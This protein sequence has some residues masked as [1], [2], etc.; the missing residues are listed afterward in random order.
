MINLVAKK[1]GM[2]HLY[3][4]DGLLVPLTLIAFYDNCIVDVVINDNKDFDN[5]LI[6]SN[7][8]KNVRKVKKSVAGVFVKKNLPIHKKIYGSKIQKESTYKIG[9]LIEIDSVLKEGDTIDVSGISIGKGFA[10][11][12]KRHN[13]S[14]LE[15]SHGVSVSHRSHGSTGQCQDPGKVFKGKRMA[16]HM[17]NEKVTIKNLRVVFVDKENGVIAVKGSIPGSKN[18]DIMLKIN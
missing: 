9:D 3:Q 17:G 5:L 2:S 15:A 12:I 13:F 1:V 4:N 11:V 10:G 18:S 8:V 6:G 7:K 14:G 16:G